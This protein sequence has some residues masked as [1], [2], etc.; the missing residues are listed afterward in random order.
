M[1]G[2]IDTKQSRG[3]VNKHLRADAL[4]AGVES[5]SETEKKAPDE[6]DKI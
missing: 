6:T 5:D 4:P 3:L 1:N 2:W